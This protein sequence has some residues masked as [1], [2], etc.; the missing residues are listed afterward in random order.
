[1][2]SAQQNDQRWFK[3]HPHRQY[4]L[5]PA[6]GDEAQEGQSRAVHFS[7]NTMARKPVL[8]IVFFDTEANAQDAFQKGC[9][10]D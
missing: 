5:R 1:M 2:T 8:G 4:R 9:Y 6:I 10:Y 3:Q 7:A